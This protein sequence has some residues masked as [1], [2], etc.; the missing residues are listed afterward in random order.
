MILRPLE[1]LWYQTTSWVKIISMPLRYQ[2]KNHSAKMDHLLALYHLNRLLKNHH[3]KLQREHSRRNFQWEELQD[4]P[5]GNVIKKRLKRSNLCNILHALTCGTHQQP[6]H[7]K[8][9][10]K[11]R[12]MFKYK[13]RKR[14]LCEGGYSVLN[15]MSLEHKLPT[16][17]D[18]M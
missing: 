18:L 9:L 16:V 2:R 7:A 8:Q 5:Y 13:Q 12:Q 15:K 1:S 10:C 3:R 11:K 14:N 4:V 6:V 17:S